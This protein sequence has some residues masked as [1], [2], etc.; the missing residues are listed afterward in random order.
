MLAGLASALLVAIMMLT[1]VDTTG[2]YLLNSSIAGSNEM[3]E[4]MLSV[5]IML[6]IPFCT[7]EGA[8]IKVD[9]LDRVLGKWGRFF[10]TFL[11]NTI[12]AATLYFLASRAWR[13]ATEAWEY[14]ELTLYVQF[15]KS[16]LYGTISVSAYVFALLLLWHILVPKSEETT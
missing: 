9:L 14:E 16:I 2:R 3:I 6:A 5:L 13:K 8:H 15:P 1:V 12:G 7:T 11:T 4:I 10:A